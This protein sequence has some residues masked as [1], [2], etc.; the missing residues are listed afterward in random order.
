VL[1]VREGE[2]DGVVNS[3]FESFVDV[4]NQGGRQ[5]SETV[6]FLGLLQQVSNFDVGIAVVRVLHLGTLAEEGIGFVD[7]RAGEEC[8]ESFP[9][10]EPAFKTPL[11]VDDVTELYRID[12]LVKL[13]N[14]GTVRSLTNGN[15]EQDHKSK[16]LTKDHHSKNRKT[17]STKANRLR[18]PNAVVFRFAPVTLDMF[19]LIFGSVQTH[20]KAF[21]ALIAPIALV[22]TEGPP[23]LTVSPNGS[24]ESFLMT[25]I[26][27]GVTDVF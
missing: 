19:P 9:E 11:G 22:H 2:L 5:N 18:F 17:R 7:R 21:Q 26:V 23:M 14:G 4:Q 20:R 10:R 13:A 3:P 1:F 6:V 15:N 8:F 16:C 25:Y 24:P 27:G 12:N